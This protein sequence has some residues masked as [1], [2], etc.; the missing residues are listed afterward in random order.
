VQEEENLPW[1]GKYTVSPEDDQ[2]GYS[3]F[4]TAPAKNEPSEVELTPERRESEVKVYLPPKAGF[5]HI[6][7]TNRRTGAAISGMRVAMM[8]AERPLSPV[9]T[10]SCYSW[11]VI[12]A[13]PDKSLLLHITSDGFGEWKESVGNGK[14][15]RLPSGHSLTLNVQLDPSD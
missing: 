11:H 1:W 3:I 13:P 9:F 15:L 12:L 6:N 14:S 2:A 7:L 4:S 10:T 8:L 5:L